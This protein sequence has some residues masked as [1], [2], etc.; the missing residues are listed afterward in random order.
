[1]KYSV[2]LRP[3]QEDDVALINKWRNDYEIQKLTCGRFR[4]VSLEIERN[5]VHEKMSHNNTEEY[6]AVCLN[7]ESNQMIGYFSIREIDVYNRKAHFAGIVIDPKFQDGIY[8][9]DTNLIALDYAFNKLGLNRVTGSCLSHHVTS[10]IMMEMLGYV[11][12][13]IERKSIYKDHRYYD[14]CQYSIL[15]DDYTEFVNNGDYSLKKIAT[16]AKNLKKIYK[17]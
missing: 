6:F 4:L 15:Y 1:M 3:F 2:Y 13:G 5:W 10:R 14:V 8:M 7:D 11:L 16:K 17:Q 9:I 12:E